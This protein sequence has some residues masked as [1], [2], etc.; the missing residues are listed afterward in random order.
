MATKFNPRR[1]SGLGTSD[2]SACSLGN[3]GHQI[4]ALI[5]EQYLEPVALASVRAI[6]DGED[7]S[8]TAHDI[9]NEAM[10][11]DWYRDRPWLI[12]EQN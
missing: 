10:W 9:P 2:E 12:R 11:V 8:L 4:I 7:D 3:E 1:A 6:L 5:A